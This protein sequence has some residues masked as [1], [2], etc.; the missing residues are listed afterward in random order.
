MK[1]I[2]MNKL[3]K[4]VDL[5]FLTTNMTEKEV[6]RVVGGKFFPLTNSK[7]STILQ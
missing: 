2:N 6:A 7:K 3:Q 4:K 5:L 1:K